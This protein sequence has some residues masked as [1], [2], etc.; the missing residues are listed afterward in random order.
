MLDEECVQLR[1]LVSELKRE[2]LPFNLSAQD[3]YN[4]LLSTMNDQL[5]QHVRTQIETLVAAK[6]PAQEQARPPAQFT[7][8]IKQFQP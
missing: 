5:A 6:A 7:A 4:T 1:D 2:G 8:F 3:R